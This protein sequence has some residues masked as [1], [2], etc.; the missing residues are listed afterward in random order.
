[1]NNETLKQF[2]MQLSAEAGEFLRNHFYT[3]KNVVE[4]ERGGVLTNID[5]E[6]SEIIKR[7]IAVAYPDH[8]VVI[9]GDE[10]QP[11]AEFVWLVDPLEG[12]SHFSRNIPIYTVNIALQQNSETILS[13][14]NHPESHQLFFAQRGSGAYLN[15]IR[16]GVSNQNDVSQAFIFV[17]LPEEKF[18]DQPLGRTFEQRMAIF[19]QLVQQAS[20]IETFR[21]GSFGQCLV[22]TGA[23]DAYVDLSSTSRSLSQAAA[24][25]IIGE[26][27]GELFELEPS[28]NG[29]VQVAAANPQLLTALKSIIH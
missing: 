13:T 9:D 21:I 10:L 8:Q 28:H 12:S 2:I 11:R 7:R 26:A 20:Q 16:I 27:G 24:Q 14:V 19:S 5:V 4:R 23:F 22:A 15:G 17:E 25:L 6:L 1:M 3:F 29:F 18:K